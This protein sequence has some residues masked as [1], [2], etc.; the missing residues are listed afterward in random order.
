VPDG[1]SALARAVNIGWENVVVELLGAGANP[2][3]EIPLVGP[4]LSA[5][6]AKGRKQIVKALVAAGA[7]LGKRATV[8]IG[9]FREGRVTSG[10]HRGDLV[11]HT[12]A[13]ARDATPLIIAVR[14]QDLEMVRLLVGGGANIEDGDG[15][16]LTALA[17]A[18]RL[19][20]EEIASYL[21]EKGASEAGT[22]G[23]PL[24]R[25]YVAATSG[26]LEELRAALAA[27]A[28]V[29]GFVERRGTSYTSLMRA[30]R[31]GRCDVIQALLQAGADP[32]LCGRENFGTNVTPLMLAARQGHTSAVGLLLQAGANTD[33][34]I[35]SIFGHRGGQNAMQ[36]AKDEGHSEIVKLLRA[37]A[38]SE[39]S[40]P[41]K[42]STS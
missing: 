30:A 15:E 6:V 32:N 42:R 20:Y 34:R 2:N 38:R 28:D 16:G 29:N 41:Q 12:P 5:A 24:H 17:W 31:A 39:K 27:G 40:K 22:E 37:A 13:I 3:V 18:V 11:V 33:I 25:L 7:D 21:R 14:C 35:G 4:C 1:E 8:S 9:A 23:N 19:G 26:D 36:Q 10:E